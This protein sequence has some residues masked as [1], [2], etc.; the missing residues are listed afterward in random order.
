LTQLSHYLSCQAY[1]IGPQGHERSERSFPEARKT[2]ALLDL[3][4]SALI[5]D[6][7]ERK[8]LDDI[9]IVVW[10]RLR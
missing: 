5:E 8:L 9:A 1:V 3:G 4:L 6:L 7:D 2:L 10:G